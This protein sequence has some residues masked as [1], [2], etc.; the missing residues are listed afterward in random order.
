LQFRLSE[1]LPCAFSPDN[2]HARIN[3]KD[4]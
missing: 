2:L 1:L 4:R 3:R